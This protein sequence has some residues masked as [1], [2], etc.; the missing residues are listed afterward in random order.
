MP[1]PL[2]NR[3]TREFVG[4]LSRAIESV[5]LSFESPAFARAVFD[6]RWE[7]RE[8]KSRMGH[9]SEMLHRFLPE[10]YEQSLGVLMRI[11]PRFQGFEYLFFPDY[12]ERYGI[13]EY[14]I[15][16][17]ALEH[18]TEYAS[19]EFAVR[20]FIMRYP[21]RMMA[22]MELWADSGNEHLRRLASEGCR[23]RLPWAM[24]LPVFKSDPRPILP[25]LEKLKAD[26]S[27]YVRRSVAN[28]LNDISKDNPELVIGIA[29]SWLGKNAQTDRLV[30]HAC[31]TLLKRGVPEVLELFG[32]EPPGHI[33][34]DDLVVD[35]SVAWGNSLSF[36]FVLSASNKRLGKL[37]IEYGL[38]FMKRNG[39]T[40]RKVFKISE[41]DVQSHRKRVLRT[42]AFKPISTRKYYA[43]AH[44]IAIILN[45]QEVASGAFELVMRASCSE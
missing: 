8:L 11:A 39:R 38:D 7:E 45:G 4:G 32:Y 14:E 2:K 43:G 34:I 17:V 33:E 12:V 23:P 5:C 6:E 37:R 21:Q 30:K 19:S 22:Q 15:S 29:Q 42:H 31:R 3:Y 28:N 10:G 35:E 36:S 25:I 20:P 27:E 1:E 16:I 18:F 40:A 9:L 41:S 26:E 44:G 13:E 24:A